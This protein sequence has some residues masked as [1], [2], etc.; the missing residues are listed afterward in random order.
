MSLIFTFAK[1]ISLAEYEA[2]ATSIVESDLERVY[3][4]NDLRAL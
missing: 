2:F 4:V 3:F 1:M